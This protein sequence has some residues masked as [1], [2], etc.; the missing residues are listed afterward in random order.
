MVH[1]SAL[2]V[3]TDGEHLNCGGFSFGEPVPFRSL[4][5]IVDYFSSL[6]LSPKESDLGATFRSTT[7]N[8]PPSLRAMIEDSNEEFYT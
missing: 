7:H 5:L 3:T 6:S 2:T 4:E 1:S 8:G